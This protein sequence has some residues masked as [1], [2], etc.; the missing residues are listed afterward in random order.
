V[1]VLPV[2][3]DDVYR[4]GGVMVAGNSNF[5][6]IG[7]HWQASEGLNQALVLFRKF[8]TIVAWVDVW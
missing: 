1:P 4:S 3:I 6:W 5:K 8:G 2:Q 7:P